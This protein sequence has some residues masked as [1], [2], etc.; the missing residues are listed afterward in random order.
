MK[1]LN[2]DILQTSSTIFCAVCGLSGI[3]LVFLTMVNAVMMVRYR[4]PGVPRAY[5][6]YSA[7]NIIFRPGDLTERGLRA[8]RRV[9]VGV[10]GWLVCFVLFLAVGTATG[11]LH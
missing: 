3:A 10:V 8:R 4:K 6:G 2:L 5:S 7:F 1:A 9:I 11:V